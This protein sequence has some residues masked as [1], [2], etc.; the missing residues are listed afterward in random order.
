MLSALCLGAHAQY[1]I[2]WVAFQGGGGESETMWGTPYYLRST[3]S[4]SQGSPPASGGN[5]I[6]AGHIFAQNT[7]TVT[8]AQPAL[9][10]SRKADGSVTVSWPLL[11]TGYIVQQSSTLAPG[12]WTSAPHSINV[13]GV[14][15][16][17]TVQPSDVRMFYRLYK[18]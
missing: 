10:L 8:I 15:R 7:A 14:L 9:L 4:P 3:I 13:N 11:S 12:S 5:F 6:L 1:A 16:W 18:P 17:F 2:D